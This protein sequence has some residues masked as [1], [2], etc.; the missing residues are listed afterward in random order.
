MSRV[1]TL[2]QM[3]MG[4]TLSTQL[5]SELEFTHSLGNDNMNS[6]HVMSIYQQYEQVPRYL[7]ISILSRN[8][9]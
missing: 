8:L 1:C 2:L 9:S 6:F 7:D 4:E 3:H 5:H